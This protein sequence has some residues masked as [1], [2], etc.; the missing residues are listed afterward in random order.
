MDNGGPR[1]VARGY[2]ERMSTPMTLER[3]R[4]L[5]RGAGDVVVLHDVSWED[6]VRLMEERGEGSY[7]RLTY[8]RGVLEIMSPSKRHDGGANVLNILVT[9]ICGERGIDLLGLRSTTIHRRDIDRGF[10]PDDWYWVEPTDEVR[11]DP[12]YDPLRHPAPDI[13]VEVDVSRSSLSKLPLFEEFNV[14]EV[15]RIRDGVVSLL[16]LTDRGYEPI[17]E[18]RFVPG[19]TAGIMTELLADGL[20]SRLAPWMAR[21]REWA[22]STA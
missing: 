2:R 6:Y 13:V 10:E 19:L 16:A 12:D 8:D 20:A 17:A 11:L 4:D 21:V 3:A 18:T 1:G 9:L 7:P 14:A 15:W 5:L 22:R